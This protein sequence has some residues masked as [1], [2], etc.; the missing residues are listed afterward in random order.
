L[1]NLFVDTPLL[2]FKTF[3]RSID[4][5]FGV[6]RAALDRSACIPR[7]IET[8]RSPRSAS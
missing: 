2:G 5:F 7:A 3:N 1:R 4:D 6:S 8:R